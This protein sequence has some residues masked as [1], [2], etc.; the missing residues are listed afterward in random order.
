MFRESSK[1]YTA[2][3]EIKPDN[4][5][6]LNNWG[7]E[8]LS[9]AKT[10][11]G[12]EA[13]NL[14]SQVKKKLVAAEEILLGSGSYNLA[15]FNALTGNENNCLHWLEV[16]RDNGK[17]PSVEHIQEDSDLDSVRKKTW[18]NDFL[19]THPENAGK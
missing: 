12:K 10:K 16:C 19:K 13:S 1:K 15:C 2:S 14:Y 5:E 17:L 4:H 3:L 6:A 7:A 9:Q 18:F 8:L 11:A